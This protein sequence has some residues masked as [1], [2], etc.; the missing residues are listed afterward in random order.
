MA[1]HII[2]MAGGKGERLWPLS[3]EERPKQL[4][5]FGSGRTLLRRTVDRCLPLADHSRIYVITGAAIAPAVREELGDLPPR[6]IIAEPV[7]RNTAP[8]IAFAARLIAA[9]DPD[10]SLVVLPADHLI[11]DEER[12]VAVMQYAVASLQSYPH[13][14]LTLGI[15]PDH[16]ETGYGYIQPGERLSGSQELQLLQVAAFC[17]KPDAE[18]AQAYVD[19]GYFWNAGMF[20]W[21]ADTVLRELAENLPEMAALLEQS[22]GESD[23]DQAIDRFY[24]QV[25]GI[26]ID[27]GIMEK[28]RNVAV[29]PVDF[30]WNDIG[31]W[32]AVDVMLQRDGQGNAFSGDVVVED[33]AGN[34]ICSSGKKIVVLGVEDLAV[35][36]GPDA[37]LV[38]PRSRAQDVSGIAKKIK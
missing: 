30:G 2:I 23:A 17:E 8:C 15:V 7:G 35:V 33:A 3:R 32:D 27:Y 22:F 11:A 20:V 25:K 9:N 24:A 34:V 18:R 14:L 38:C 10:A 13:L 19:A 21:R 16:A 6:N 36:E 29:I 1:L 37:I 4:L 31:S 26:S 28:S 5:D 12:F